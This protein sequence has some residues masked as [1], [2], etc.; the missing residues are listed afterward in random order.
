[1]G[2]YPS[3]SHAHFL[4]IISCFISLPFHSPYNS[5]LFLFFITLLS[6]SLTF[7]LCQSVTMWPCELLCQANK[8]TLWGS[9]GAK[10]EGKD[11]K[12]THILIPPSLCRS[13][14]LCGAKDRL[15]LCLIY[16]QML[17]QFANHCSIYVYHADLLI[18]AFYCHLLWN[19]L[20]SLFVSIH[21]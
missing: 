6:L 18:F 20:L 5:D 9:R 2:L 4:I 10:G 8:G 3:L 1:M 16:Y 12:V 7:P 21:F 13:V 11:L 19:Y 17:A 15:K 14:C